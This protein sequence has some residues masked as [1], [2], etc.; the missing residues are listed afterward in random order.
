MKLK[1]YLRGLGIGIIVTTIILMIS[2]SIHK[3]EISDEQII[4]RAE[5][6][7]MEFPKDSL[8]SENTEGTEVSETTE[9]SDVI[10]E[11]EASEADKNTEK[12]Q[13][14]EAADNT[15]KIQESETADDSK[16]SEQEEGS[17]KES[18]KTDKKDTEVSEK[19]NSETA[20]E[21]QDKPAEGEYM[22]TIQRGAVC[23]DICEELF[24]NGL[25][26]DSEAFRVY[27]GNVGYASN[28][29]VGKYKISYGL[30]YEEIYHILKA[31]PVEE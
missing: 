3:E 16:T 27:L 13:A 19:D 2:F 4:A 24:E 11:T 14:S 7:G 25:V 10:K 8:F 21:V 30:S 6:L 1:Y 23:R 17:E 26:A 22:L 31:G 9:Q 12:I 28:M 5:A 15:E 29:K 18:E 20:E